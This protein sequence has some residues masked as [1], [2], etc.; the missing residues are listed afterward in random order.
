MGNH[1]VDDDV[2]STVGDRPGGSAEYGSGTTKIVGGGTSP[3]RD[4]YIATTIA[5]LT[6]IGRFN[7]GTVRLTASRRADLERWK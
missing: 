5:I 3:G 7:A 6:T 1:V 4:G 2:R